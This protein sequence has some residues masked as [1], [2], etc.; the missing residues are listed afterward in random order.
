M[1]KVINTE[2]VINKIDNFIWWY[3]NSFLSLFKD[4]WIEDVGIIENNYI[5]TSEN[6]KEQILNWIHFYLK[7][8]NVFWYSILEDSKNLKL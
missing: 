2:N 3:L 8:E 5:K 4:S 1:Y 7:M 6:L